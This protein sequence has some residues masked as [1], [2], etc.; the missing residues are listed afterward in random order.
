MGSFRPLPQGPEAQEAVRAV[1]PRGGI[2]QHCL[3]LSRPWPALPPRVPGGAAF[4]PGRWAHTVSRLPAGWGL[5]AQRP[6]APAPCPRSVGLGR[7]LGRD[8]EGP[9][10]GLGWGVGRGAERP[11]RGWGR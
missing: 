6:P 4:S 10:S 11:P 1:G 9:G 2:A 3:H 8:P 7:E 5:T